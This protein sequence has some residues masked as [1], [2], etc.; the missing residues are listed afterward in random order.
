LDHSHNN[1]YWGQ[2]QPGLDLLQWLP[3]KQFLCFLSTLIL[4]ILPI[5][6]W[7]IRKD[8]F[9]TNEE[10]EALSSPTL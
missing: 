10:T 7:G 2:C 8:S 4:P 9:V 6:S 1:S 5:A 3:L